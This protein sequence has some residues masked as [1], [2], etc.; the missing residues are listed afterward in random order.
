MAT[1]KKQIKPE[2][3]GT[4]MTTSAYPSSITIE[5]TQECIELCAS[6]N[7]DVFTEEKPK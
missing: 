5:N 7:L 1:P 3:I 6:I 4:I 2:L